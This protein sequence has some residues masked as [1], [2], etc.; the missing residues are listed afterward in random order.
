MSE[1]HDLAS[2][3]SAANGHLAH[4]GREQDSATEP[5]SLADPWF[6]PAP[7]PEPGNGQS[8]GRS[9]SDTDWFLRTGRAGLLPDSMTESWDEGGHATLRPETSAAPPWAGEAAVLPASEPPP[10]ESGPWPGPDEARP[11]W[12][13]GHGSTRSE[14]RRVGKECATLCRSRWS[15]YH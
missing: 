6:E 14:E 15:P 4:I 8:H 13:P 9:T 12:H 2:G 3:A 7:K 1:P 5:S 11:D 10:W